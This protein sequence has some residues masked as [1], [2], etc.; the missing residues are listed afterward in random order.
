[1]LLVVHLFANGFVTRGKAIESFRGSP[2]MMR[3]GIVNAAN[4]GH[5]SGAN[6]VVSEPSGDRSM[7]WL[8]EETCAGDVGEK[9]MKK[10]R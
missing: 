5:C 6:Q 10:R 1:M 3:A 7:W 2:L 4:K 8:C 9:T